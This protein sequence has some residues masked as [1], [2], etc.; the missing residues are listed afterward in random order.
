MYVYVLP[1]PTFD[2]RDP[3]LQHLGPLPRGAQSL[4]PV[5][6]HDGGVEHTAA[7][8]LP[9]HRWLDMARRDEIILFPPQF[10]LLLMVGRFLDP[11]RQDA[12]SNVD[13]LR[14]RKALEAFL[15]GGSP[16]PWADVCISPVALGTTIEGRTVLSLGSSGE[17]VK[18]LGRKGLDDYVTV[19]G[20]GKGGLPMNVDVMLRKDVQ[21]ILNKAKM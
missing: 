8:F 11:L 18:N 9:A 16:T 19:L 20:R 5:P 10:F 17:E 15:R 3:T 12:Y 7:R 4:I 1:L 13:F 14:Q 6:T 21:D 2:T